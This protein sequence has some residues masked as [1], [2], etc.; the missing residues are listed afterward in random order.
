MID[1]YGRKIEYMR[2][3]VTDRCNLH[4]QFCMPR[5][6]YTFMEQNKLLTIRELEKVVDASLLLGI[7][8][9][10]ITGGE[11]LLREDIVDLVGI[12]KQ[13]SGVQYVAMTTNGVLLDKY[14]KDLEKNKLDS[15][16]ISL[17]SME[18][19]TYE[20]ITGMPYHKKVLQAIL[21][22]AESK[23]VTK[24]NCV[25]IPGKNDDQMIQMAELARKNPISMRFIEMMPIGQGN[26]FEPVQND[27]ILKKLEAEYGKAWSDDIHRGSGP[28]KYWKF[29]GFKGNI[30]FISARSHKFCGQCNRVRLTANG[31]LK[32]CLCEPDGMDIK[33]LL[34]EE[35]STDDLAKQMERAIFKK[36]SQHHF[37]TKEPREQH[38]MGQ[39]GG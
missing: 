21:M 10:R 31:W 35:C 11:P 39:I 16:N 23:I 24:V 33:K 3:S 13:K 20:E 32:L 4:C 6:G 7:H 30:G 34:Q 37:E 25:P 12:L 8:D 14:L 19:D 27:M 36:P 29:E 1:Q 17:C 5:T 18:D 26:I 15:L 2:I 28:A 38:Y 9:F 22:A